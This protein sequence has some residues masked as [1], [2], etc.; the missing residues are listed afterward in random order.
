MNLRRSKLPLLTATAL[1][2]ASLSFAQTDQHEK[3]LKHPAPK[4]EKHPA[5]KATAHKAP[6][7]TKHKAP[8]AGHHAKSKSKKRPRGQAAIDNDRAS[9]IQQ[10]LAREHYLN[11][12]PSG[13]WDSSTQ[14]AMRRYQ[15]DHGW[16]DK[17]VPD[18]RALISLGLGPDHGH[19]LN[20]ETAMTSQAQLPRATGA[21]RNTSTT[22]DS[23]SH[24]ISNPAAE[25][26][27]SEISSPQSSNSVSS[28]DLAAS[29]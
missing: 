24:P 14:E 17:T 2:T 23:S 19:L 7:A 22:P 11:G 21:S 9:Q 26:S 20:P 28:S 6:K 13:N 4:A 16:Q 25:N 10:A 8:A 3:P 27:R 1:L 5:P 29:H 15:A 18:S 12:T